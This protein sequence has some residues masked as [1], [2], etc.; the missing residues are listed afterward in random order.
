MLRLPTLAAFIPTPTTARD[1]KI[2]P[3]VPRTIFENNL[4]RYNSTC[5]IGTNYI[6]LFQTKNIHL[7]PASDPN[8]SLIVVAYP[9]FS[10]ISFD[11]MASGNSA[12]C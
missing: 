4:M 10:L 1:P 6:I 8:I 2:A 7:T 5:R 12:A 3:S 11:A 9:C